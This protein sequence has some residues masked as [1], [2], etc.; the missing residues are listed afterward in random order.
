M[1]D[2]SLAW[3]YERM[4]KHDLQGLSCKEAERRLRSAIRL[5]QRIWSIARK[6]RQFQVIMLQHDG[7]KVHIPAELIIPGLLE[8]VDS[9]V[10]LYL[11]RYK[12]L[13][14]AISTA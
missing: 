3:Y 5:R 9:L 7:F 2:P 4:L 1:Y 8:K 6:N 13:S 12:F 10:N 14:R 11:V